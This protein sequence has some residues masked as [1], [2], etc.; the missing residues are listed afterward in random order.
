MKVFIHLAR[1]KDADAWHQSWLAGTLVGI[2]DPTPYGYGRAEKMGCELLYSKSHPESVMLKTLRLA[3]RVVLGFDLVHAYRQRREILASDVVWTHTESQYLGVAALLLSRRK[4]KIIG[5][6]VWLFDKWP[7]L[8]FAHKFLYKFLI[9][10][11]DVLTVHSKLNYEIAAKIFPK[12][13][14]VI[15]PF[16]IPTETML[17]PKQSLADRFIIVSPGSDRH[18]D[19]PTLIAAC[20]QLPNVELV[21][22][23]R[24]APKWLAFRKKNVKITVAKTND[25]LKSYM[26]RAHLV[27]VPLRKNHHASGITVIQEAILFGLPVVAT[28][29]GGLREYFDSNHVCYVGVGSKKDLLL[30]IQK[31]LA[32]PKGAAEMVLRAQAHIVKSGMGAEA[33]IRAH[34]QISGELI[35]SERSVGT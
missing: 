1:N 15:V 20:C 23:S 27:S 13:N 21:I 7:Q 2:N 12:K 34:V 14:I 35:E 22:L 17:A 4:P 25:E 26:G 6:S 30:A 11:V 29:T 33:F 9:D 32:N 16:G 18:R 28:D 24:T 19:W 3:V 8:S 10:R 5:Q 31:V